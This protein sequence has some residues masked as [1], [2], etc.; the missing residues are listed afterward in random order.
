MLKHNLGFMNFSPVRF[1][2]QESTT[3]LQVQT[4]SVFDD[5]ECPSTTPAAI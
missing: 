2:G 4:D 3:I 5:S 1:G